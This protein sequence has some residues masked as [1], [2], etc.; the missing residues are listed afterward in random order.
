VDAIS[1]NI[2][3][4]GGAGATRPRTPRHD[5]TRAAAVEVGRVNEMSPCCSTVVRR[6]APMSCQSRDTSRYRSISWRD[7][8]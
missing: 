7:R 6:S 4:S 1:G 5:D 8:R 3:G 2:S